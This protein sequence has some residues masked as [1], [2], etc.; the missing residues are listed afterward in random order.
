MTMPNRE[1]VMENINKDN[2]N[3]KNNQ[4]EILELKRA[5]IEMLRSIVEPL[6]RGGG[7]YNK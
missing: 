6:G 7:L 2:R 4:M 3:Y 5:I 1:Y